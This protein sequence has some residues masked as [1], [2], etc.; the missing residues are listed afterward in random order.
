M[1]SQQRPKTR[2]YLLFAAG[3]A[4]FPLAVWLF[5]RGDPLGVGFALIVGSLSVAYSGVNL[6]VR[7]WP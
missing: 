4:M 5:V 7:Q 3:L 1:S 6:F 2:H